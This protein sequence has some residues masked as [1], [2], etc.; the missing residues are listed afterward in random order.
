MYRKNVVGVLLLFL[1]LTLVVI[2]SS[3]TLI[4]HDEIAHRGSTRSG[5]PHVVK[6]G[7]DPC[8]L[9]KQSKAKQAQ[10]GSC[11]ESIGTIDIACDL[12]FFRAC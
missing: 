12:E 3:C 10:S 2:R 4:D 8:G 9:A 7:A 1:F 5:G 6:R 11:I